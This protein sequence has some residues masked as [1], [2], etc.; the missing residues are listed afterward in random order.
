M[1]SKPKLREEDLINNGWPNDSDE[2]RLEK[3]K[4]LKRGGISAADSRRKTEE[5]R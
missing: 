1:D 2:E 3:Q 4:L 5:E